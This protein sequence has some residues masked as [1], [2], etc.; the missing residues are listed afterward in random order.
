[1]VNPEAAHF[2][3]QVTDWARRERN[4][5]AAILVGSHSRGEARPDSDVDIVLLCRDPSRLLE[6]RQWI[7]RFGQPDGITRRPYKTLT[8]FEVRFASGLTAELGVAGQHWDIA[9]HDSELQ[10]VLGTEP[11]SLYDARSLR[12]AM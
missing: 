5:A 8:T 1:M 12:I 10:R 2:I 4:V 11:K 7:H 3:K 9:R 6:S